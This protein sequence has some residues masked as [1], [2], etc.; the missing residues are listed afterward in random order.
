MKLNILLINWQDIKNP[1]GGGAEVHAHEIFRRIAAAGHSVTQLSCSFPGAESEELIDGI[2][3]IRNGS[4]SLFNFAVP[5][6]YRA[7]CKEQKFDVVIDDINKIPFYTPVFVRKPIVAILHHLF[8]QS[9]HLE[10]PNQEGRFVWEV[11]SHRY[12]FQGGSSP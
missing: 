11:I 10:T 4:R 1:L 8:G 12:R 6:A 9:N 2:R 3:V 7:L 5:A